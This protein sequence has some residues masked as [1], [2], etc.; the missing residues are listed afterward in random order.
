LTKIAKDCHSL[1]NQ[2]GNV[3]QK[4]G[5]ATDGK[6]T[7]GEGVDPDGAYTKEPNIMDTKGQYDDD[8][9]HS[10]QVCPLL[11]HVSVQL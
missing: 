11:S 3:L 9:F 1:W 4:D 8:D 5:D 10:V 2:F 6:H 7:N